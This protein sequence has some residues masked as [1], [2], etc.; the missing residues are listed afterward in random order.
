M[1]V[2]TLALSLLLASTTSWGASA[3]AEAATPVTPEALARDPRV[4]QA[5]RLLDA[6]ADTET[7]EKRLPGVSMAVVHDQQLLW[8]RG[9]GYAHLE[10]K[11]ARGRRHD[12]LH[13]LDLEALHEHRGDAAA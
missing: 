11:V 13:L 9:F 3:A 1:L 2:R 8:S 12:V 4:V 6:W 5:L 10:S 7:V